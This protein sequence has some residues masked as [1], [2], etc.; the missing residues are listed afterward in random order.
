MSNLLDYLLEL[1]ADPDRCARLRA[2]PESELQNV[3]LTESEKAAI[4]TR[5]PRIISQAIADQ[6]SDSGIVMQWLLSVF[7]ES[8]NYGQ[9]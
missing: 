5:D 9:G 3:L 2:N 8:G 7:N 6:S 4:T 1:A